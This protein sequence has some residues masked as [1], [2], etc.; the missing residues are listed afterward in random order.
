MKLYYNNYRPDVTIQAE[1]ITVSNIESFGKDNWKVVYFENTNGKQL[2]FS[3]FS[4]PT[5]F[6]TI[7]DYVQSRNNS[8][9]PHTK[10]EFED[11]WTLLS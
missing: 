6:L 3:K 5:R 9:I 2:Q 1:Q 11:M 7:G 8:F 10:V 4:G